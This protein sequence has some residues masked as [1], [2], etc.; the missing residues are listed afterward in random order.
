MSP[1][2]N[3]ESPPQGLA[4]LGATFFGGKSFGGRGKKR[5]FE[6]L[7]TELRLDT[8]KWKGEYEDVASDGTAEEHA[9]WVTFR[10]YGSRIAGEAQA[11]DE[12]RKW[13][14]EGIAYKDR[15][16]YVYV[17]SDPN[18]TSIG[19]ASFELGPSGD[20]LLGQWTGWS[21]DG[22]KLDPRRI[23]LTKVKQ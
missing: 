8:T 23:Q 10:Q 18:I 5:A 1:D 2:Q 4:T 17:D 7:D 14:I 9:G 6:H 13:L 11:A 15:L 12:H 3:D 16:C 19:T 20:K 21:P 22:T